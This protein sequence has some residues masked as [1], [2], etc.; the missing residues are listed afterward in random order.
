MIDGN[1]KFSRPR[2]QRIQHRVAVAAPTDVD[3][4]MRREDTAVSAGRVAF[5]VFRRF[6]KQLTIIDSALLPDSTSARPE[7]A[8]TMQPITTFC[9]AAYW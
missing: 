4:A 3:F 5:G 1:E 6:P 2:G 9:H 8:K 7:Q